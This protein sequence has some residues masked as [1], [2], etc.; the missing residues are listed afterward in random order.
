[1]KIP[2]NVREN[3]RETAREAQAR[4]IERDVL[5]VK[6]GDWTAKN[7]LVRTMGP[8][9]A[10][11]AQK[12]STDPAVVAKYTEAGKQGL[13]TAAEKYKS[14]IGAENFQVFALDF[15]EKSMNRVGKGSFLSRLF[16]RS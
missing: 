2:L 5:A 4:S 3:E 6:R 15:I 7:N 14:S 16:G 13:L 1:M 9:I 10:S 11:I 12:R 8:L